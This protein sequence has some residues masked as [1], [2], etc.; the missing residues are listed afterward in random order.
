MNFFQVMWRVIAM[1]ICGLYI[2]YIFG[3]D[4]ACAANGGYYRVNPDALYGGPP[5]AAVAPMAEADVEPPASS[6][7][8]RSVIA[9]FGPG[10]TSLDI[11]YEDE[12]C[13]S[14]Y[15]EYTVDKA[16]REAKEHAAEYQ[17]FYRTAE[18][19]RHFNKAM[20]KLGYVKGNDGVWYQKGIVTE[21]VERYFGPET[22]PE[23]VFALG[24][25][26]LALLIPLG[27]L[28]VTMANRRAQQAGY[29]T[30][31]QRKHL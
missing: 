13:V 29:S 11:Q 5:P 21:A 22:S 3:T 19:I 24:L 28:L 26:A 14:H 4:E 10:G 25:V 12:L 31:Y 1:F 9:N 17:V 7:C 2:G 18:E 6:P 8:V 30:A 16:R 23:D 20:D 27:Y 15:T